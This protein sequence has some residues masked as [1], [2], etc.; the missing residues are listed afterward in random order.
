MVTKE[1]EIKVLNIDVTDIQQ[2][3]IDNKWKKISDCVQKVYVFDMI[4]IP[5]VYHDILSLI[6]SNQMKYPYGIDI[7]REKAK[8]LFK[9]M[10]QTSQ[11]KT[12]YS[13]DFYDM[14]DVSLVDFICS[15]KVEKMVSQF[16]FNPYKW[17]R[18]RQNG[19]QTTLTVKSINNPNKKTDD[20]QD[21]NEYEI[22]VDSLES[23][24]SM[25]NAMGFYHRNY[26]EK[27]RILFKKEE[28]E[29]A[30]DFWPLL[31]PYL[32]IEAKTVHEINET[33]TQLSLEKLMIVSCNVD[34]IYLK[35]GID[36]YS[37]RNLM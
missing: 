11:N 37:Y 23:T 25:L 12:L 17:I 19:E 24:L 36:I 6:S 33:I 15:S 2:R 5:G 35:K 14:D 13:V 30:I 32:E 21:V 31:A 1:T 34:E 4:S 18:L 16:N 28:I 26:Q 20:I 9:A 3:L 10:Q 22:I 8:E 27:R 29:C 7:V